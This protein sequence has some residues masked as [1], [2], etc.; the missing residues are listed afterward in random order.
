MGTQGGAIVKDDELRS[1]FAKRAGNVTLL[2]IAV[3]PFWVIPI[4]HVVSDRETATGF[5][6]YELPYYVAN[7]RAAFERGNGVLYPNP[8]DPSVDSPSIYVHWLPWIFG[9][10]TAKAG[11]DPGALILVAT[12][13]ASIGLAW[14]TRRFV[15]YRM[16]TV[17]EAGSANAVFLLAMWGGGL[18][19]VAGSLVG[20]AFGTSW[21]ESVLRYDPG[22][23][24]W[25][26]N[27]GRNAVFPTE[28]VYHCIAVMCWLFEIR[29]RRTAAN[30]ALLLLATTHPWSG[31]ELLLTINLWRTVRLL[32]DRNTVAV[33]QLAVSG[34]LLLA[35]LGYYKVW[36]PTFPQHAELQNVWELNW[37]VAWTSAAMAYLPV[38]IP[39]FLTVRSHI[40]LRTFN[41]TEQFLVCAFCVAAG[42]AF[43]DRLIKPVQP[44]HFT[45]GYVWMPLFLLAIPKFLQWWR[46]AWQH[47]TAARAMIVLCLVLFVSDNLTF[48]IVH[49]RRHMA[50]TEGLYLDPAEQLLCEELH[51]SD[52]TASRIVMSESATLNY[53]LPAYAN[54]RPWLGHKFNTPK[55]PGRERK[56][57]A[58]FADNTVNPDQIPDDV[59]VLIVRRSRDC[60]PLQNSSAWEIVGLRNAEW[61]AWQRRYANAKANAKAE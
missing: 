25:F 3:L 23:G 43:H 35:F 29:E 11:C 7:G 5:F 36:L 59:R 1:S 42:L 57:A 4:A 60:E 16:A 55:F 19:A 52:S 51:I 22:S 40:Q 20:F 37:S 9:Y 14:T 28:A 44:I 2:L 18:L 24:L 54:V 32:N 45:R 46:D 26:L 48:S 15:Q 41:R 31:L 6:S 13:L 56:W 30:V 53:M 8:Y 38:V 34:G 50:L 47:S 49:A 58:C 39:A 61:E 17:S 10:C 21:F 27:W 12:F 33:V